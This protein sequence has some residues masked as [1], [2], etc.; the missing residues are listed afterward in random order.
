M[1]QLHNVLLKGL[2]KDVLGHMSNAASFHHAARLNLKQPVVHY[3]STFSQDPEF[4]ADKQHSEP[5]SSIAQCTQTR[6]T[7]C[8]TTQQQPLFPSKG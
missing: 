8:E 2:I 6:L 4:T 5:R 7:V 1:F 3:C